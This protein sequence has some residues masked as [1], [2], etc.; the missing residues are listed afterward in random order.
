MKWIVMAWQSCDRQKMDIPIPGLTK[1][2]QDRFPASFSDVRRDRFMAE[3]EK[4]LGC[5]EPFEIG[6][7][8]IKTTF[9]DIYS[10]TAVFPESK[11]PVLEYNDRDEDM[12]W[13]WKGD[14]SEEDWKY[15][16]T[17]FEV[18]EC[19]N[20]DEARRAAKSLDK[21]CEKDASDKT[22]IEAE[23]ALKRLEQH[24]GNLMDKVPGL[25]VPREFPE[26]VA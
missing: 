12:P 9:L 2:L 18:Q 21:R 7:D 5:E 10:H 17:V 26:K 1:Y 14:P 23:D 8:C 6:D 16:G 22:D 25:P 4:A 13:A 19:S 11:A 24:W 15:G 3:V 20:L